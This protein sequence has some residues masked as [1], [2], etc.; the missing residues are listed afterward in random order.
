[1]AKRKRL[2]PAQRAF[3]NLE[4]TASMAT[5]PPIAQMAGA[6]STQ[7]ALEELSGVVESARSRGLMI[8]ELPLEAVD[9]RYLVRDRLERDDDEMT[10]LI[11]S[12]RS[13]GQQTP[14]EVATLAEA[15]SSATYGL[16]SG[17]RRLTALRRLYEETSD[18][19]FSYV[20]ARV[21]RPESAC[22]AYLS[23]V[24]ENEIRVNLSHYERARIVVRALAEGVFETRKQALQGLFGNVPRSRRSKIG[25]FI[26]LVETLDEL[27]RHPTAISERLG[28]ALA[29]K[30]ETSPSFT[31]DLRQRLQVASRGVL[32]TEA[33]ISILLAALKDSEAT[34][35]PMEELS[36]KASPGSQAGQQVRQVTPQL[37]LGYEPS[38][39]RIEIL[40]PGVDGALLNELGSWLRTYNKQRS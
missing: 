11:E 16:I 21:V 6:V 20:Q 32:D 40:G 31:Q 34:A 24:E 26:P 3:L 29:R 33:E 7:A 12:L 39:C 27:L 17:W 25:S 37:Q 35:V 14:I 2:N 10:A 28:L 38:N 8:E 18:P 30:M 13:R 19:K 1:M 9:G 22:D 15:R 36:S 4:G 23:M 5:A